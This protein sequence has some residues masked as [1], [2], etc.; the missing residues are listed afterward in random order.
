[1]VHGGAVLG[2]SVKS[3]MVQ[4][5]GWDNKLFTTTAGAKAVN[6]NPSSLGTQPNSIASGTNLTVIGTVKGIVLAKGR[7]V[8]ST[9]GVIFIT[10]DD[11][12][13][14]VGGSD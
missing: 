7:N 14:F 11:K 8:A 4:S 1:M 13:V 5:V 12:T 9:G 10:K 6:L 3:G 2:L